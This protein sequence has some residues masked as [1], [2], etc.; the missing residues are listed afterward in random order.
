MASPG[1][2]GAGASGASQGESSETPAGAPAEMVDESLEGHIPMSHR[3]SL[4]SWG[5]GSVPS[6]PSIDD[7]S[8]F[9]RM[10]PLS[11]CGGSFDLEIR[12]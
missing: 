7:G 6:M 3:L 10:A 2:S 11:F 5:D 8:N 1:A 12:C 9:V 4:V